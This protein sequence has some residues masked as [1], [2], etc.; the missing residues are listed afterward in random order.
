MAIVA[1]DTQERRNFHALFTEYIV[2]LPSFLSSP[3]QTMLL[4]LHKI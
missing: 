3:Q 2:F 4:T 1:V